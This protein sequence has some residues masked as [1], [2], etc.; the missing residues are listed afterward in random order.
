MKASGPLRVSTLAKEKPLQVSKWL[1]AQVL[2]DIDEMALLLSSLGSFSIYQA[3][4][5]IPSG[6]GFVSPEEFLENY[7]YYCNC[8][9]RGEI[10][11]SNRYQSHFCDLWTT[12][13]EI[14]YAIQINETQQIIK[15]TRPVVQLQAHSMDYSSVDGEFRPMILGTQ[16]ILW[17]IQFSY[18]QLFQDTR[19]YELH[20]IDESEAFPNTALFRQL[21]RWIRHNTVATPFLVEGRRI[22]VPMRIGKQCFS[23][24]NHHPQLVSRGF[25]VCPQLPTPTKD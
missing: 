16:S 9:K 24:I 12:T 1:K 4:R 20:K 7:T 19:T 15:T 23:W 17:G 6:Q 8:L 25:S 21:Q 13:S 14:L 18:P 3:S 22:N 2:L 5:L 10:P 11:D